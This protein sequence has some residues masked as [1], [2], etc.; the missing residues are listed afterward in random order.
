MDSEV[1]HKTTSLTGTTLKD[2]G[3]AL[4]SGME[5]ERK[6]GIVHGHLLAKGLFGAS[7]WSRLTDTQ[8][9]CVHHAVAKPF[10]AIIGE[11]AFKMS[12]AAVMKRL[13]VPLAA[14]MI[15]Q[16]RLAMLGRIVH[17]GPLYL[18]AA[19]CAAANGVNSWG[20]TVLED[21]A[22][23]EAKLASEG[24]HEDVWATMRANPRRWKKLVKVHA[25]A[26]RVAHEK[27]EQA[28]HDPFTCG[29][30][31][32]TCATKAGLAAHSFKMHGT[33]R[34]SWSRILGPACPCC[35]GFYW[36]IERCRNHVEKTPS[37]R[38]E[39]LARPPYSEEETK[40]AEAE[41][42]LTEFAAEAKRHGKSMSWALIPSTRAHG[43][44]P[45][46]RTDNEEDTG[47]GGIPPPA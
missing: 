37:C 31:N 4:R 2:V 29:V 45:R 32:K 35:L 25:C 21:V 47:V 12:S 6:V 27:D 26:E 13:G 8:A 38:Q 7:S 24:E 1:K 46:R 15:V 19:I 33:R 23:I 10:R 16:A 40:E 22:R 43:P 44:L 39:V 42:A 18:R 20:H 3:A 28:T 34:A 41:E 9:A 11:E 30:C 17:H 5:T 36:T 14:T